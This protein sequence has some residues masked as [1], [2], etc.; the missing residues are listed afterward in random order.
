ML[1]EIAKETKIKCT[2]TCI[3]CSIEFF[4]SKNFLDC[5]STLGTIGTFNYTERSYI[6]EAINVFSKEAF[7]V[8]FIDSKVLKGFL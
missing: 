5:S 7:L 6:G 3:S 8:C 2:F 4:I 1:G